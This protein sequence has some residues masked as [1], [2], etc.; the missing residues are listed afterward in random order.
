MTPVEEYVGEGQ[1]ELSGSNGRP[2]SYKL[3][4]LQGMAANGLP[5]PG[6]YRIEGEVELRGEDLPE[7]VFGSPVTLRLC[8][9]RALAITITARDGRVLSEGHGPSRCMCC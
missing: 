8:D 1:L 3:T 4:R 7:S 5:V 9:G 2:V 6:L